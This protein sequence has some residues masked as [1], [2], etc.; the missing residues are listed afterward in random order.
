M[1]RF[2]VVLTLIALVAVPLAGPPPAEAHTGDFLASPIFEGNDPEIPGLEV[3]IVYTAN[4]QFLLTNPSA[5]ELVIIADTGEPFIRIGPEGAFGNFNSPAWYS[6][7]VPDGLL[8]SQ[9]PKRA[10]PGASVE[11]DWAKV[12]KDPTWGWYDHRLHPVERYVQKEVQQSRVPVKLGSWEV[13]VKYGDKAGEIRGRFE[14]KPQLGTYEAVLRSSETPAKDVTVAVV[15]AQ[16]PAIFLQNNSPETVT[17]LG[18]EGEPFVRIGP[19][20]EVNLHSPSYIQMQQAI[21]KTPESAEGVGQVEADA[22]SP[23]NWQQVQK[24]PQWRWLE[25]RA[26]PP[27]GDP[28]KEVTDREDPTTVKNWSVPILV[29]E[30]RMEVSGITQFVPIANVVERIRGRTDESNNRALPLFAG[31]GLATLAVGYMVLRPN[32]AKRAAA[33]EKSQPIRHRSRSTPKRKR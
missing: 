18:A 11:P 19:N 28:P 2:R 4:Y 7:N 3:D 31:I 5:T 1:K 12:S 33:A 13:P 27:P 32:K 17:V 30:T 6:S 24:S 16:V 26:A 15:S 22:D 14:Y 29:G 23:P 20:V 25:F 21:A 8:P 9:I 10:K